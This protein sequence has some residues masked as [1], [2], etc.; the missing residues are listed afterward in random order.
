[1]LHRVPSWLVPA[2]A[3]VLAGLVL[4]RASSPGTGAGAPS[5]A[6]AQKKL[7]EAAPAAPEL[8]IRIGEIAFDEA[9][10]RYVAPLGDKRATLT[11]DPRL[12]DR[13]ERA[14]DTYRVPWGATVLIEPATGRILALAEHSR[15]EPGR[16]GL[17]LAALAPAASIFKLVTGRRPARAGY[18][19]RRGGLLPRRE[20]TPRP[21]A[22]RRR[23]AP[24]PPLH[25]ARVG[26]RPLDERRLREARRPGP[27]R[28]AA[29]R[30]RRALPVQHRDPV[31]SSGRGLEGGDP[32]GRLRLRGDRGRVRH[33]EA[34]AASRRAPRGH[35]RERRCPRAAG[36]RRQRRG[37][38]GPAAAEIRAA[39]STRRSRRSSR[40]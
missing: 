39:S 12:Q 37:R 7:A 14:L 31:R 9:S 38:R 32:G 28:R 20:A 16:R 29:A 1:M 27:R 40:G 11:L 33:G 15:A 30:H 3:L 4:P 8:P 19:A 26:V 36:D 24:R 21:E 25:H 5:G 10:G 13:L 23:P 35:R 6:T 17:S 22:P 34:L 18:P 2:S